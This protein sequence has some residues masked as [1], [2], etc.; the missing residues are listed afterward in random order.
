[1]S[2]LA[3]FA[4]AIFTGITPKLCLFGSILLLGMY[5]F[6]LISFINKRKS[7]TNVQLANIYLAFI[8]GIFVLALIILAVYGFA[9]KTESKNFALLFLFIFVI[10]LI[11][12]TLYLKN[13]EKN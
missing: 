3:V 12:S 4:D 8:T 1:M 11:F 5:E 7:A 10:Y 6:A 2:L 13:R 9:I